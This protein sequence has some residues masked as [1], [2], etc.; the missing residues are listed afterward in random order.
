LSAA[1]PA[2]ACTVLGIVGLGQLFRSHATALDTAIG[3][4]FAP[5][6]IT[7][8]V[9]AVLVGELITSH[10][11]VPGSRQIAWMVAASMLVLCLTLAAFT[12]VK[13]AAE[14]TAAR[15]STTKWQRLLRRQRGIMHERTAALRRTKAHY[16]DL[17]ASVPAP[18]LLTNRGGNILA[19]N[20]AMIA[21]LGAESEAQLKAV[22]MASLHADPEGRQRLL[23]AWAASDEAIHQGEFKLRRLD[24]EQ[25]SA[26]FTSHV[27]REPKTGEIDHIQ[28]TFTDITELRRSEANQRRLEGHLRL[29]QKLE[30][31]GRLAAG[32]AHEINTPMQYIGD[33]LFFIKESYDTL[34]TLLER[35]RQLLAD[36]VGR[37]AAELANELR[38]LESE[39]DVEAIL[40]EMPGALSRTDDGIKSVNRIVAAMKELAHPG[41]G[42]KV[43][44]DVSAIINTAVTVTRNAHKTVANVQ[45]DLGAVPNVLAYKNELCQVFINLIVNAAHAI[46]SA[47]KTDRRAGVITIRTSV[48]PDALR[49]DVA[50]N[51]C[52][53][54]DAVMDKIFDPFFTTK[55]VGKGTGQ[56]LALARTTIVE[57]HGGQL[58]VQS[59]VGQGTTFTVTLPLSD[60]E[61]T[62]KEAT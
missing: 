7:G 52:G 24:G 51:G 2:L 39:A 60:Q 47:Q 11:T 59:A 4:L 44:T 35:Q 26:L 20:P 3:R 15:R 19:A 56:G 33:N 43:S 23:A 48:G 13:L 6:A 21:L 57:K 40:T 55:E 12:I 22:N 62:V 31:V 32:I 14:V 18:V 37:S 16:R 46:E 25:R 45:L 8:I 41:E 28:G 17:F 58:T 49:I 10:S 42:A 29:S 27:V 34:R 30:S 9:C 5:I 61:S 53:I 50:D 54:P 36:T 1:I 38:E